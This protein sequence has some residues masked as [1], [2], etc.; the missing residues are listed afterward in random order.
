MSY[1]LCK[2]FPA[3]TPFDIDDKPYHDVI[4]LFGEVRTMQKRIKKYNKK[5]YTKDGKKIIRRPA[6]DNW[7]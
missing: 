5:H 6:S 7:F 3:L 2:E 1:S 4:V